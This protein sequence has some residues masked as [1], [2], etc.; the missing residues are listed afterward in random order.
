VLPLHS[1]RRRLPLM[2]R[3]RRRT[4]S[5][6]DRAEVDAFGIEDAQAEV[7]GEHDVL[8]RPQVKGL[9]RPPSRKFCADTARAAAS[10][11]N[12]LRN[13]T[14]RSPRSRSVSG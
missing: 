8:R 14:T 2:V 11:G 13:P 4:I 7:A 10:M 3:T 5:Q 6:A 12:A 1:S 9:A